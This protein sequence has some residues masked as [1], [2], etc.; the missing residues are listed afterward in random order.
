MWALDY[1]RLSYY[2]KKEG[3]PLA[4]VLTQ[5][6]RTCHGYSMVEVIKSCSKYVVE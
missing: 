4:G 5:T 3:C 6:N 2:L 1:C